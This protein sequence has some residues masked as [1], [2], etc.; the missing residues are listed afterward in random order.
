V[1]LGSKLLFLRLAT[2]ASIPVRWVSSLPPGRHR[3]RGLPA[4]PKTYLVSADRWS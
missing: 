1:P 3:L 4:P 2:R